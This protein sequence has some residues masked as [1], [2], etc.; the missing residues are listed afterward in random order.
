LEPFI[1][2]IALFG[3][4]FAP[5]GW[6][7]CDG[8]LLSISQNTALFSLLGTYFG[9]DGRTNF[10]LPDLRGR[11]PMHAGSGPGLTPRAHGQKAGAQ[12]H[13]TVTSH[14]H[15]IAVP[16][17][18]GEGQAGQPTNAYLAAGEFPTLPYGPT[19]D[20]NMAAFN[21]GS[22]G[23]SSVDHMNPYLALNYCIALQGI[24]P[25]QS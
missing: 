16:A 17:A 25:S 7:R 5:A 9:G 24:Y 2:Q 10:G 18:N 3:F 13:T 20:T 12:S 19:T 22:A 6:A 11:F 8:Q 23:S 21:S 15:P 14:E 1:G 4:N